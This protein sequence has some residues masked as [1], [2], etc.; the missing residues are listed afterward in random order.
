MQQQRNKS[1]VYNV[2]ATGSQ[3]SCIFPNFSFDN[4]YY[5]FVT[6]FLLVAFKDWLLDKVFIDIQGQI[7][8]LS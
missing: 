4:K 2:Y 1:E 5:I 6:G 8:G 3:L 7:P